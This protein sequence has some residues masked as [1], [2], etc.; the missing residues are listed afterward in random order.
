MTIF[1]STV[2]KQLIKGKINPK[3]STY[4]LVFPWAI[5]YFVF[6]GFLHRSENVWKSFR[7]VQNFIVIMDN[8]GALKIFGMY[9]FIRK[10]I[11]SFIH[12]TKCFIGNV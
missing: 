1:I 2:K 5:E 10:K 9:V 12:H 6:S 4:N 8:F 3:Q 7:T 11:E